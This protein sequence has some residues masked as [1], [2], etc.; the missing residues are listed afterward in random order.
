[1]DPIEVTSD[2]KYSQSM[3][4]KEICILIV[5]DD[6][7]CCAIV[8]KMIQSHT[9]YKVLRT[10]V[11]FEVLKTIEKRKDRFKLVLTNVHRY[12]VV[13]C[14]SFSGYIDFLTATAEQH[15]LP[16]RCSKRE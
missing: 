15:L 6:H 10:G 2:G 5:D 16:S 9:T 13:K 12:I 8:A 7:T 11:A 4:N 3:G 14:F 1:M